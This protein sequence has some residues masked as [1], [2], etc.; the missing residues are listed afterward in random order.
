MPWVS[1]GATIPRVRHNTKIKRKGMEV[2]TWRPDLAD[3]DFGALL[4]DLPAPN[5]PP[6]PP[7]APFPAY[8]N[9]EIY[10]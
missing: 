4:L 6:L 5:F 2:L 3:L 7:L 1:D 8:I 10:C 9:K